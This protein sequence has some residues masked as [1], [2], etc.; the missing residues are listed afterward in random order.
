ML[1][2]GKGRRMQVME[3]KKY[4]PFLRQDLLVYRNEVFGFAAIWIVLFHVYGTVRIGSFPGS[5]LAANLLVMGN[6]GVDIFLMLSAIGLYAAMEKNRPLSVFYRNRVIRVVI[7]YLLVA[8]PYFAWYDLLW[9]R[10]GLW[11]FVANVSSLNFWLRDDFPVWYVSY[12]MVMYAVYPL[13]YWLDRK[14]GH[15]STV[16]LIAASVLLE[17]VCWK[18]GS[19]IYANS[20]KALSRMPVFLSGILLAP[21]ILH[22][23]EKKIHPGWAA[24]A[25][26]AWAGMFWFIARIWPHLIIRRYLYGFMSLCFLVVFSFARKYLP[27]KPLNGILARVGGISLE[28]YVVHVLLLRIVGCLDL[29]RLD[30]PRI[31]SYTAV[32]GMAV[33]L[34]VILQWVSGLLQEKGGG[35]TASGSLEIWKK[36]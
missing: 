35:R 25:F 14:S 13:L 1:P 34:A 23:G 22:C 30:L 24:A 31:I 11:Q 32:L 6:S 19:P 5:Y 21:H 20:E 15:I 28:V 29:W 36:K 9:A 27:C 7:P 33:V 8:V 10:D 2:C 17:Y 16:V 26:L 3:K 4:T 18:T 12:I